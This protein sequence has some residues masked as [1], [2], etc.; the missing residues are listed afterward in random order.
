MTSTADLARVLESER[1]RQKLTVTEI[2]D[3]AGVSRA[4]VYRLFNG[5]DVQ[6]TTLLAVTNVLGLDLVPMRATL[7]QLVPDA[8]EAAPVRHGSTPASMPHP[9][10]SRPDRGTHRNRLTR[11]PQDRTR[12]EGKG[13]P[14]HDRRTARSRQR[15]ARQV[16]CR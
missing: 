7:A 16:R 9:N 14:G 10:R 2:I 1:K 6:L 4:A 13:S 3:R 8:I 15:A 11:G 5:G 12:H